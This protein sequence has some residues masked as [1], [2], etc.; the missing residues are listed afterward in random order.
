MKRRTARN[1]PKCP[2]PRREQ[3]H[4]LHCMG[5]LLESVLEKQSL[6]CIRNHSTSLRKYRTPPPD[7]NGVRVRRKRL[8]P[9]RETSVPLMTLSSSYDWR[10]LLPAVFQGMGNFWARFVADLLLRGGCERG[11]MQCND[12]VILDQA[13]LRHPV[14]LPEKHVIPRC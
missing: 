9:V 2:T 12:A 4:I 7:G 1:C 6:P 5:P 11:G 3:P 14:S 13:C 10:T 8:I